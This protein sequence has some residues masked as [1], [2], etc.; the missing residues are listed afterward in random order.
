MISENF[1]KTI[2]SITEVFFSEFKQFADECRSNNYD[3]ETMFN[4]FVNIIEDKLEVNEVTIFRNNVN[5]C[6]IIILQTLMRES[7]KFDS[8]ERGLDDYEVDM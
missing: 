3:D 4:G 1:E 2:V 6:V 7:N 8:G 5:T